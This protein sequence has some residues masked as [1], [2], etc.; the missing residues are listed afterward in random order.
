MRT[1]ILCLIWFSGVL[2]SAQ[3]TQDDYEIYSRAI[4]YGI[5]TIEDQLNHYEPTEPFQIAVIMESLEFELKKDHQIFQ[6]YKDTVFS[7]KNKLMNWLFRD[8]LMSNKEKIYKDVMDTLPDLDSTFTNHPH[9]NA[10]SLNPKTVKA[11]TMDQDVFMESLDNSTRYFNKRW[12]K[13]NRQF[14]HSM[15]FGLSKIKY[16]GDFAALYYWIDC[17][18]IGLCKSEHVLILEKI[19]G[20]WQALKDYYLL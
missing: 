7:D 12:K 6:S 5:N 1:V 14:K 20:K 8:T 3:N 18:K 17:G 16:K 10:D 9:I 2:S 15:A 4:D 11:Y 19:N 13:I